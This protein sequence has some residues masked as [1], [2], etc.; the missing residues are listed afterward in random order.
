MVKLK[1]S[2]TKKLTLTC[3]AAYFVSY[4]TRNNF[5]AVLAAIIQAGDIDKTSAGLVTTLGFI[6]YGVGQ[7]ISGWLGDRINPKKLMFIGF[8][9]TAAMNFMIPV[10]PDGR[11]MCVVWALNGF[12]QSFMWP[13]MVK[14]MRTAMTEDDYDRGCVSVSAGSTLATILIYLISPIIIRLWS[15]RGVF[16]INASVAVLMS[17]LWMT[18]VTAIE[19]SAEITYTLKTGANKRKKSKINVG[20]PLLLCVML[21]IILQG[22]MRDGVTTWIP[23]YVAEVFRL[24]SSISILSGVIIPL[25]GLASFKVASFI[26]N[27]SGKKPY[28]CAGIL[29]AAAA[30]CTAVLRIFPDVSAIFTVVLSAII[31]AAMHGIN[32]IL[33]CYLPAVI[34]DEDNVSALSGTLNFMTYVG[35]A[36][37]TYGFA[38]LSDKYGW[39]GTVT[40]WI[41]VSVLGFAVCMLCCTADRKKNKN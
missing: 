38:V 4:L 29:F 12:A 22:S 7:L 1:N 33:I 28:L 11:F 25:F 17:V 35:S 39:S 36:A 5:A 14:I 34:A 13:P 9:M 3:S 27:K 31:V 24:D 23:T 19:K 16:I 40:S 30:V 15:W 20:I 8:L 41:A 37:S 6:T 32:L 18:R 21:A 10:C 26:Y 2:D